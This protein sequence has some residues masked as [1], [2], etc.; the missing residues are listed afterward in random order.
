[1]SLKSKFLLIGAIFF[2]IQDFAQNSFS[3]SMAS[4]LHEKYWFYRDRMKYFVQPGEGVGKSII[5][6]GRNRETTTYLSV[7]DQTID[8]GYYLAIPIFII[9]PP[10]PRGEC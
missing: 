2:T 6:D 5:I 8:L 4:D 3:N 10:S 1:M 9:S 7:G